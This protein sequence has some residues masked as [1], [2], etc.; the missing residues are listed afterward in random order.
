MTKQERE[1]HDVANLV[2]YQKEVG[3]EGDAL[4]W[5]EG[6]ISVDDRLPEGEHVK[7]LAYRSFM[8]CNSVVDFYDIAYWSGDGFY[9]YDEDLNPYKLDVHYWMP[10][11]SPPTTKKK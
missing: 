4:P 7:A 2:A 9:D 3:K 10:L 5:G 8:A 11:P 1:E 6:W